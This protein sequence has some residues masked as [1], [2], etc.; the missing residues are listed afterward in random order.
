MD[1]E[2]IKERGLPMTGEQVKLKKI[3]HP[4]TKGIL[5]LHAPVDFLKRDECVSALMRYPDEK[6][7]VDSLE[8]NLP[9]K[10][11]YLLFTSK[12]AI[13]TDGYQM[14]RSMG[15]LFHDKVRFLLHSCF[16]N[17]CST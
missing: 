14:C 15:T 5:I 12:H 10:F 17:K 7:I 6:H 1:Y 11:V 3:L 8:I 2:A 4:N 16:H 13:R 9:V